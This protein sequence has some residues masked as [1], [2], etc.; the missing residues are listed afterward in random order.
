VIEKKGRTQNG[1]LR[2]I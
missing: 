2:V 1:I